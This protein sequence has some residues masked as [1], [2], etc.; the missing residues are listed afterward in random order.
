MEEKGSTGL[1][2]NIAGV[3]GY[4]FAP[5][6]SIIM[7]LLE[8]EDSTVRF[9]AWQGTLFGVCCIVLITSLEIA[10]SILG[11]FA[12]FLG[13]FIGLLLMPVLGIAFVLWA[14]CVVKAYQGELWRIPYL[15]DMAAKKAGLE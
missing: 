14:V 7:L 1:P 11:F 3:L 5:L 6:T 12:S 2:A 15:G 8:K 9:H 10:S 4:L 13:I